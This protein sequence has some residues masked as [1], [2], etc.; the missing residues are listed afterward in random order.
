MFNPSPFIFNSSHCDLTYC[1]PNQKGRESL[2][3][4]LVLTFK[5]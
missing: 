3:I 4:I 1:G 2:S 5:S